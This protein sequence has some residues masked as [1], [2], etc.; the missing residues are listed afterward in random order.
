MVTQYFKSLLA[1]KFLKIVL[2]MSIF[3]NYETKDTE[4]VFYTHHTEQHLSA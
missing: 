2:E 4:H 3:T 1:F